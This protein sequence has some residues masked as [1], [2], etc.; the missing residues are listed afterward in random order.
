MAYW[1]N[2]VAI[3]IFCLSA[4]LLL[5]VLVGYPLLLNV[6]AR[7]AP[8]QVARKLARRTVSILLPVRNGERWIEAK[9]RC[10]LELDY[11]RDLIEII[12]ISD[13]STD[14]TPELTRHFNEARLI[15]IAH[16][17]KAAALNAGLEQ[18]S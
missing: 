15:E 14:R 10:L 4:A 3:L 5:Y 13:G 18:A 8:Q 6:L 1:D 7:L 17:G 9:L 2:R 16:G 11:P 12:V